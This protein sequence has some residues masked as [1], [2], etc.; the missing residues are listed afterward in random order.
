MIAGG[1]MEKGKIAAPL[2][3]LA[4]MFIGHIKGG[5]SAAGVL[6]CGVFG[7]ISGSANATLTCIGGIMMPHLKKANYPG[8]QSAALIVCASPLAC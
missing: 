1:I 6:A 3:S 2:V 5:L 8:G 4:E 7:S